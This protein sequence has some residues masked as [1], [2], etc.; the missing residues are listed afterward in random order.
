M[1]TNIGVNERLAMLIDEALNP[2]QLAFGKAK[3]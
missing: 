2:R 1:K 3:I